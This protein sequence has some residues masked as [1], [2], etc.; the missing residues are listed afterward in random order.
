MR[1]DED[2]RWTVLSV[3]SAPKFAVIPKVLPDLNV[4]TIGNGIKSGTCLCCEGGT[5]IRDYFF[6]TEGTTE[7]SPFTVKRRKQR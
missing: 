5:V 1:K 3:D 7:H 2:Y 4:I 6:L